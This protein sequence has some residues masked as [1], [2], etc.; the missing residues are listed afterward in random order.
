MFPH[1]HARSTRRHLLATSAMGIG[2]LALAWLLK[3]DD[4]L[5]DEPGRPELDQRH[6]D[7]KPKAPHTEPR[8]KAM[9]SLFVQGGPSYVDLLDPKPEL[10]KYD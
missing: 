10:A 2:S 8:A 4:L 5:A 1:D 9:I 6:F 3:Q 7:L